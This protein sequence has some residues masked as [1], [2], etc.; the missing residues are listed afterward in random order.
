MLPKDV[1]PVADK[2]YDVEQNYVAS[3][4]SVSAFGSSM[5][6]AIRWSTGAAIICRGDPTSV[7]VETT[8]A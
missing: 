5:G 8:D 3:H 7:E 6:T 4:H 2:Y 1:V